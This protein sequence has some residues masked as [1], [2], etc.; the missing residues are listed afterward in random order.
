MIARVPNHERP[1]SPETL[2]E[3]LAES[4]VQG[5]DE[6][7]VRRQVRLAAVGPQT[8]CE[9]LAVGDVAVERDG[10]VGAGQRLLP[11]RSSFR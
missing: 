4:Q 7:R 1:D 9:S 5:Q 8:L 6:P 3:L 11:G 2:Y 10:A